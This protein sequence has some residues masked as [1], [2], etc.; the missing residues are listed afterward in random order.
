LNLSFVS[1]T[2]LKQWLNA[3]VSPVPGEYRI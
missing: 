1:G 3:I 2:V